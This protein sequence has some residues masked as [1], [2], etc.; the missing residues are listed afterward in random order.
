MK[1]FSDTHRNFV[2]CAWSSQT[3]QNEG[4]KQLPNEGFSAQGQNPKIVLS[5]RRG[6]SL[7]GL[8]QSKITS[9]FEPFASALDMLPWYRFFRDLSR[10]LGEMG[11]QRARKKERK[12]GSKIGA[13]V[14]SALAAAE[15]T[16]PRSPRSLEWKFR[17]RYTYI[18]YIFLMN[19]I[20]IS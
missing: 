13:S 1:Q 19:S 2:F 6:L 20:Y 9:F 12:N 18:P 11:A 3:L 8:K 5:P 14:V 10:F 16:K 15:S 4:S 7:R 17:I